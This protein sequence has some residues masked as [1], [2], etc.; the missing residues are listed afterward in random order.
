MGRYVFPAAV[1]AGILTGFFIDSGAKIYERIAW[2]GGVLLIICFSVLMAGVVYDQSYDGLRYHQEIVST[3]C[4]GWNPHRG[5]TD[6]NAPHTLWALHYAKAVEISEAA[7][8]CFTGRIETGKGINLIMIAAASFG[9]YAFLRSNPSEIFIKDEKRREYWSNRKTL[10]I[11]LALIGNPVVFSQWLIYYI[12]LYKYL[13]LLMVLL[14]FYLIKSSGGHGA[15]GYLMLVMT[16]VLA[17]GTKFNFFFEAGVWMLLAFAWLIIKKD[18]SSLRRLVGVSFLAL[19][20]GAILTYHPYITNTVGNG[21]P[22]YPLMGDGAVDIMSNNTPEKFS[23]HSRVVNF[24]ISLFSVSL[25]NYDQRE[26][27]FTILMPLILILSSFI[28]WKERKS[29]RGVIWYIAVCVFFS[30]FIFEQTWWA[31]Y[32]CQLWLVGGI[33][34]IASQFNEKAR[35]IGRVMSWLMIVTATIAMATSLSVSIIR[36]NYLRYLF[37][38]SREE[39]VLIVGDMP[40]Q[41]RRHF[42]EEKVS[43]KRIEEIPADKLSTSLYYYYECPPVIIL[44]ERQIEHIDTKLKRIR[45]SADRYRYTP[46]QVEK[47]G[48]ANE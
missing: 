23:A 43:Y 17:M 9:V 20:I 31:R 34:L 21:H 16:L 45:Q 35:K 13:Y 33:F 29:L 46:I 24:F 6:P 7:I 42:A 41:A 27:G 25:P 8:V 32:I 15:K 38:A 22:L 28:A 48:G 39:P 44:S 2:I 47:E 4:D 3:L 30:C 11:T 10:W 37:Q 19:C 36:G 18:F 12:D 40:S 14:A 1:A 26:G 5:S